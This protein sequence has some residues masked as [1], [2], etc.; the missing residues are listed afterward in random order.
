MDLSGGTSLSGFVKKNGFEFERLM[1][2]LE[3][4]VNCIFLFE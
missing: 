4:D 3:T 1:N 2:V